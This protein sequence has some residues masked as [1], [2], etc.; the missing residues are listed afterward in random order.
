MY[1]CVLSHVYTPARHV[2]YLCVSALCALSTR[3]VLNPCLYCMCS[4]CPVC[5]AVRNIGT[6]LVTH[7]GTK[8][9]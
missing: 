4:Y 2:V 6:A 9:V 1:V 5:L 8:E 7:R 3:P